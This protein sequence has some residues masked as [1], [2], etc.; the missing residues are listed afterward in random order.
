MSFDLFK[1]KKICQ[2]LFKPLRKCYPGGIWIQK[3][4]SL[5][6]ESP[7][8]QFSPLPLTL[9][10]SLSKIFS[11]FFLALSLP[12]LYVAPSLTFSFLDIQR[13]REQESPG[14]VNKT[15]LVQKAQCSISHITGSYAP[16]KLSKLGLC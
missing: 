4:L 9:F 11:F 16:K 6:F 5:V 8:H 1:K 7:L 3:T 10:F 12:L 2:C 14:A 13:M 15:L